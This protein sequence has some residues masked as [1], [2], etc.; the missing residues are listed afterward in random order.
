MMPLPPSVSSRP[1]RPRAAS[2]RPAAR[3]PRR[4][5]ALAAALLSVGAACGAPP[6]RGEGTVQGKEQPDE[7][8]LGSAFGSYLAGRFAA[9]ETDTRYAADALLAALRDDPEQP[10]LLQ[11]AFMA[12]V[13]DGR[14]EAQTL[15][16]RLPDNP[17]AILVLGA[18][19]AEAGRWDRAEARFRTLP[20]QGVLPVLNPLL[21]AWSQQ[22]RG[23]PDQALATLR[24]QVE[25]GQL[26]PLYAL[27]AAMIA[28]LA[29]RPQE[30][31]R[32]IRIAVGDARQPQNL[33][34]AQIAAGI[35]ARAGQAA[36]GQ[37]LLDRLGGTS[38]EL[39]L[40]V[41]GAGGRAALSERAVGNAAQG[42]AEAELALAAALRGQGSPDFA[43]VLT[44]LA[45]RLR[46]DFPAAR[47]LAAEIQ[48]DGRHDDAALALLAEVPATDP[49]AP[50]V[51]L[52]RAVLLDRLGRE[53][54][55]VALLRR[56]AEARPEA[57]QPWSRL[58]D[59]Q[60]SHSRWPE[61]VAAYD[62]ALK[63]IPTLG[64]G[65]WPLLY[66]RGIS[67]ERAGQW[68]R[69]E[70]DLQRALQLA[71]EQPYLLNYLGYTWVEQG[72]NLTQ[73]RA[74][75]QRAVELRPQDGNIAD[76]LGWALFRLGD[77]PGAITWMEKAVELEPRN[78][79]VNDH[80]GDVYW[81][82]GRQREAQFQWRRALTLDPEPGEAPKIEAKLRD[83]LPSGPASAALR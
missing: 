76:S 21:I 27:H 66:A 67:L 73:A 56:L 12:T 28:D 69:A 33:R 47:L 75:L 54:E 82:A 70:A 26:R 19:D 2:C 40:A 24:P 13:L 55:A 25:A 20:R 8:V 59:L 10:E 9:T 5:A 22:G 42:I 72:R 23:L 1:R 30:A 7:V 79:T 36:E 53:D 61:A 32:L 15:A 74:M 4:L 71:P 14:P 65:D 38:E 63:R 68:P 81:A 50:V 18:G 11:R 60:R 45:L 83:G 58:G 6:A 80:L 62:E 37:G 44:R 41:T 46:P 77:I 17:I 51:T 64:A 3:P 35:L 39:A 31:A 16:R 34:L 57:V 29:D 43:L 49:L 52:R 48:A 78:S